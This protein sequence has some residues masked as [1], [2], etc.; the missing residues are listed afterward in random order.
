MQYKQR[1]TFKRINQETA[2]DKRDSST[3]WDIVNMNTYLTNRGGS[4]THALG[5]SEINNSEQYFSDRYIIGDCEINNKIYVFVTKNILE[6]APQGTGDTYVKDSIVEITITSSSV[7]L[8]LLEEGNFGF[9]TLNPVDAIGTKNGDNVKLYWVDGFNQARSTNI[10]NPNADAFDNV[11]PNAQLPV[12]TTLRSSEASNISASVRYAVVQYNL[13]GSESFASPLSTMMQISPDLGSVQL[14]ITFLSSNQ[15][16]NFKIFRIKWLAQNTAPSYEIIF[17]GNIPEANS[18]QLVDEGVFV[19]ATSSAEEFFS[20]G[21]T[22]FIPSTINAKKQRAIYGNYKTNTFEV[23]GDFR[24]F[25]FTG[26]N[27]GL[28]SPEAIPD[29]TIE[30]FDAKNN[31]GLTYGI[32]NVNKSFKDQGSY[33]LGLK[34]VSDDNP[35]YYDYA[36][37]NFSEGSHQ[38]P[39]DVTIPID[40][41]TT[42]WRYHIIVESP[43][44]NIALS[45][46]FYPVIDTAYVKVFREEYVPPLTRAIGVNPP[47]PGPTGDVYALSPGTSSNTYENSILLTGSSRY[48][49]E[50][51]I[52][53]TNPAREDRV[54]TIMIYLATATEWRYS[55]TLPYVNI[56]DLN[57]YTYNYEGSP[58]VSGFDVGTTMRFRSKN[59]D[60]VP[61]TPTIINNDSE[62]VFTYSTDIPVF[63]YKPF[64][65]LDTNIYV[66]VSGELIG[67][68]RT[69]IN[70]GLGLIDDELKPWDINYYSSYN[71][72]PATSDAINP[73]PSAFR[74]Q[75]DNTTLGAEGVYT[76]LKAVKVTLNLGV[77]GSETLTEDNLAIA[78]SRETYR[79]GVVLYDKYGRSSPAYWVCDYYI[80]APVTELNNGIYKTYYHKL[81]GTMKSLPEGVIGYKFVYV[82]RTQANKSILGQGVIQPI[83][84]YYYP[85]SGTGGE[86]IPSTVLGNHPFPNTKRVLKGQTDKTIFDVRWGA[87]EL[88]DWGLSS[89]TFCKPADPKLNIIYS[90][91]TL[92]YP[93]TLPIEKIVLVGASK[94]DENQYYTK[95]YYTNPASTVYN[96]AEASVNDLKTRA[97]SEGYGISN[98][99]SIPDALFGSFDNIDAENPPFIA[100]MYARTATTLY[101]VDYPDVLIDESKYI[102][103]G[104]V[105]A[106]NSFVISNL[107]NYDVFCK[108][109]TTNNGDFLPSSFQAECLDG[110]L[111]YTDDV[112]WSGTV[113]E[114]SNRVKNENE[115]DNLYSRFITNSQLTGPASTL[116]IVDYG[117]NIANQYGGK[118]NE[119]KSFNTY[120][121]ASTLGYGLSS[122]Q[123]IV[124]DTYL[125]T[126]TFPKINGSQTY[127]TG[128]SSALYEFITVPLESSILTKVSNEL[129]KD[130]AKTLPS[131]QARNL[132]VVNLSSMLSYNTVF[133]Q[134][135]TNLLSQSRTFN[136]VTTY[137]Y[138]T[139]IV[140]SNAKIVGESV[141]AWTK[142]NLSSYLDLESIYGDISALVRSQETIVAF[143]EDGIA[144]ISILPESQVASSTGEISLGLGTVLHNF[145]YI[146]TNSGT[147]NREAIAV[148]GKD[149]Y[150]IDTK[151]KT[152]NNLADGMLSMIKGFNFSVKAAMDEQSSKTITNN[153]QSGTFV[154]FNLREGEVLFRFSGSDPLLVYN[155][156]YKEFTKRRTYQAGTYFISKDDVNLSLSGG[157][158]YMHD[159]GGS[160]DA[161]RTYYGVKQNA[162]LIMLVEPIPGTDKVFDSIE[163]LKEGNENFNKIYVSAPNKVSGNDFIDITF[164]S[165]F[166]KHVAYFPRVYDTDTS[167]VTRDRFRARYA[168]IYLEYTGNAR[169]AIDEIF[170]KFRIKKG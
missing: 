48:I 102:A 145:Q 155:F 45:P 17:D 71:S 72:I 32:V 166:D 85:S 60:S 42:T 136:T 9:S 46:Y 76:K 34:T 31:L 160:I 67:I 12:I 49:L 86:Y 6:P 79:I 61:L 142:V 54:E 122:Y 22:Y 52:K 146:S 134:L 28:G 96:D 14:S 69:I 168:Y 97:R 110:Y 63:V 132:R 24:A 111:V 101:P 16:E 88:Y 51:F 100:Y 47:D 13:E 64:T 37:T 81:Q 35:H 41:S 116:P 20:L 65:E 82:P 21:S 99:T 53:T 18:Y 90:P 105:E 121:D 150:F 159:V 89:F 98:T 125:G 77:A 94:E 119:V 135:P 120:I 40:P 91:E 95:F 73:D 164:N 112:D 44:V 10:N 157:K 107:F 56:P 3:H 169:L 151:R 140:A 104:G 92:L 8:V 106:V 129:I 113:G 108:T 83:M 141:D 5:T 59:G 162:R 126:Y 103:R 144:A 153:R 58:L 11:L 147:E 114:E 124:L 62:A 143:Q 43:E 123:D 109:N 165:K 163:I 167:T 137:N 152:L 38:Y 70:S 26:D 25:S 30:V 68:R 149:I 158:L 27:Y 84:S 33:Y 154:Y 78:K 133:S 118:S 29:D 170:V 50:F 130:S 19:L 80:P 57:G 117:Q 39:D 74:Y 36:I 127:G 138:N 1:Y 161:P 156:V 148:N 139:R 87:K 131:G 55:F 128:A 7:S 15:Y 2:P 115:F 4:L 93:Y 75:E 66:E 23:P